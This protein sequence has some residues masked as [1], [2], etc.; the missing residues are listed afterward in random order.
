MDRHYD[1]LLSDAARLDG[2]SPHRGGLLLVWWDNKR[3]PLFAPRYIPLPKAA[4]HLYQKTIDQLYGQVARTIT[5]SPEELINYC[6]ISI[7]SRIP[8]YGKRPLGQLQRVP[9]DELENLFIVG[10]ASALSRNQNGDQL[11]YS[12]LSVRNSDFR[13][14]LNNFDGT[15]E[16]LL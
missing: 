10:G 16:G 2:A 8:L 11:R 13:K 1:R 6:G 14:M 3:S 9:D 15:S 4:Q 7:K 12:D 5:Q